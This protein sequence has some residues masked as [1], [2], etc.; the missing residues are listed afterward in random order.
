MTEK[1]QN[2]YIASEIHGS[3]EN[4]K[5]IK[6]LAINFDIDCIGFEWSRK[7]ERC[8]HE[9]D[10]GGLMKEIEENEDGKISM[11]HVSLIN[12]L[13]QKKI[14]IVCVDANAKDWNTRDFK[15]SNNIIKVLKTKKSVNVLIVLGRMHTHKK[16]FKIEGQEYFSVAYNLLLQKLNFT[17]IEFIYGAGKIRNF[18]TLVLPKMAIQ[19]ETP[20]DLVKKSFREYKLLIPLSHPNHNK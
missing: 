6:K 2:L 15:I 5:A 13:K 16:V 1:Q 12:W 8:I 17:S 4:I 20:Y 19:K 10:H 11:E 18:G 7:I 3:K 14:Q 9:N